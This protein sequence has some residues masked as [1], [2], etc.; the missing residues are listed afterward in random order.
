MASSPKPIHVKTLSRLASSDSPPL[1]R[2]NTSAKTPHLLGAHVSSAKV[3]YSAIENALDIGANCFAMFLKSQ[4]T[5]KAREFKKD[6]VSTFRTMLAD[7]KISPLNVVAHGSYLV[8][9]ASPDKE[10]LDKSMKGLEL[11][12]KRAMMLNIG[13][14]NIH[15]GSTKNQMTKEQG[16]AQVGQCIT[17]VLK[18]TDSFGEE[19]GCKTGVL[20]EN[21]CGSGF[22]L[23][24]SISELGL[25]I[26]NVDEA[27][28]ERVGVT[29]D[30]AHLWGSGIDCSTKKGWMRIIQ[31]F[32]SL[33][34]IDKL[35]CIHVNE[36]IVELNSR[37]DRHGNLGSGTI[38]M[39][40]F[41]YLMNE[42]V[43]RGVNLILETPN[44]PE[45][46]KREINILRNLE[47][48]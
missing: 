14:L 11:E 34:G 42:E 46:W 8:N 31:E 12:I 45:A 19:N 32:E 44:G 30:T 13:Y 9:L 38:G 3:Y 39:E 48:G 7:A 4:R 24:A 27:Y 41:E 15:P 21:T 23:G 28:R 5:W 36:S 2:C 20:L 10:L 40:C 47:K 6:E 25:I 33:I 35:K 1:K 43:F 22:L 17:K 29:L 37:R 18:E 26:Q 16:C